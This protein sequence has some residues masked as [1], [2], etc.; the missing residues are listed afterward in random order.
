MLYLRFKNLRLISSYI[1]HESVV[2][3]EEYDKKSLY[4]MLI[5]CMTVYIMCQNVNLV[6]QIQW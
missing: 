6:V 5:K 4:L 1:D 2:I 3:V